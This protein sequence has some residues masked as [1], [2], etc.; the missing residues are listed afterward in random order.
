MNAI[1][2]K[3]VLVA[4]L[5]ALTV[6]CLTG[7]GATAAFAEITSLS[8]P[9]RVDPGLSLRKQFGYAPRYELNV[10]SFD[11]SNAPCI[12]G[13][14][15]SQ[16]VTDHVHTWGGTQWLEFSLLVAVRRDY[17]AFAATV[18]A[19][20]YVSEFV[21]FDRQG[22]AYTLLEIRLRDGSLKN[23]LLYSLDGCATWR[24][25]RLPV[26]G[27][28]APYNGRDEG[29]MSM[30]RFTGHNLGDDPPLIALWRP[31]S[32]W[33]GPR[34]ARNRLYVVRPEFDGD[35]LVLPPAT[36]V[37]DR[38]LGMIQ[39]A[40]GASF[41]ATAGAT[42]FIVWTEVAAANATSSPT[43]VAALDRT[44]G[45]LSRPVMVG[46]A[47]PA[48]DDH[49]T[50]GICLDGQGYVHVIIG[51]H[52]RPFRYTRSVRPL[53]LSAWT[54]P[55]P[56]LTSGFRRPGTDADGL[57]RQT[58]VS[59]V[60][61]PDDT[62]VLVFR[63]DRA[64]VDRDFAGRSY[65]ALSLQIKPRDGDWSPSRRLV[66]RRDRPGY[67]IYY[68]KLAVDRLGRLFLSLSVCDPHAYPP[69]V[70]DR[71]RYHHRMVVISD[72]AGRSWRFAALQDYAEG[73]TE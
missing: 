29:T 43:Y 69:A 3:S 55:R 63:Q 64:G 62:L 41:A 34:A 36:L 60:C 44:T 11:P 40:G 53:D 25:A 2:R 42:S 54:L 26:D 27:R 68:Q 6:A 39:A 48:N 22:R 47:S 4:I 12:R 49:D 65:C 20:G 1:L 38:H 45:G 33:P 61:L 30:E 51:A 19:G 58:Y 57:G 59:F 67:A 71:H 28:R 31:V 24:T 70:R 16:H 32:R 73:L 46:R 10:P 15:A 21:E 17:P 37:S 14:T 7:P 52:S 56:T 13:R 8:L 9:L 23:L 66:Q 5:S 18:N 72:D 35:R 50:P